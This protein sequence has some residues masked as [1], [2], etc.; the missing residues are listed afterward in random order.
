MTASSL[1]SLAASKVT[2]EDPGLGTLAKL[3]RETRDEIYRY[4]VKGVYYLRQ[5]LPFAVYPSQLQRRRFDPTALHLSKTIHHEAEEVYFSESSF[6]INLVYTKGMVKVP[7]QEFDRMMSIRLLVRCDERDHHN[8][9]MGIWEA[10]IQQLNSA[11]HIRRDIH[12]VFDIH[13]SLKFTSVPSSVFYTARSLTRY[14]V[15]FLEA[16]IAFGQHSRATR[17]S[18]ANEESIKRCNE[19]CDLLI[20]AV[21]KDLEPSLGPATLHGPTPHIP[22]AYQGYQSCFLLEFHPHDY[23][24]TMKQTARSWV[25]AG[26]AYDEADRLDESG[27]VETIERRSTHADGWTQYQGEFWP[28]SATG[29]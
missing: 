23:M 2:T 22:I 8:D 21:K 18:P 26:K 11:K 17:G 12:V 5:P 13:S 1:T 29:A 7:Q 24:E 25:K 3:P 16:D 15:V 10:T 9:N 28:S 19:K 27:V 6:A 20:A 14:R 4:L